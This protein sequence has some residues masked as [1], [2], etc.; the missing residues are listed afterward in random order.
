[1][2]NSRSG[3]SPAEARAGR[4][5]GAATSGADDCRI[6]RRRHPAHPAAQA[7]WWLTGPVQ[8]VLAGPGVLMGSAR[9]VSS[10][11]RTACGYNLYILTKSHR[12]VISVSDI[13][14]GLEA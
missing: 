6:S 12:H 14:R 11:S 3:P 9:S 10:P 2:V 5:R 4:D 8:P 7:L 13:G 1:V